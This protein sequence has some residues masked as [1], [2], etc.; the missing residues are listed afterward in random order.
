MESVFM[1]HI[2]VCGVRVHVTYQ[3]ECMVSEKGAH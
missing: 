3:S 1:L 2:G